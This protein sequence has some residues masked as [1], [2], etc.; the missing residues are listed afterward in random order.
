MD[1]LT[2]GLLQVHSIEEHLGHIRNIPVDSPLVAVER[3]GLLQ[4]GLDEF[5]QER[6]VA[7]YGKAVGI[8]PLNIAAKKNKSP[9]KKRTEGGSHAIT[10]PFTC[11]NQFI[12][13]EF[14]GKFL[15]PKTIMAKKTEKL[16]SKVS[17]MDV[18]DHPERASLLDIM[19]EQTQGHDGPNEVNMVVATKV[20]ELIAF[21]TIFG[22][23]D[24][25]KLFRAFYALSHVPEEAQN[26]PLVIHMN[27]SSCIKYFEKVFVHDNKD[28]GGAPPRWWFSQGGPPELVAFW[29]GP[30]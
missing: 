23:P 1:H 8:V 13:D 12:G 14:Q 11:H 21:R 6:N 18:G 30:P 20:H 15:I 29:G 24:F 4:L 10:S 3:Q 17:V 7:V 19:S 27:S 5:I 28:D 2:N 26:N 9:Q 16:K 25:F 22:G